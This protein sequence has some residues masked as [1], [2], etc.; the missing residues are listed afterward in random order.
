MKRVGLIIISLLCVFLI[1][2][3][4]A[5]HSTLLLDEY[6]DIG[7]DGEIVKEQAT[8]LSQDI[9]DLIHMGDS[10]IHVLESQLDSGLNSPTEITEST[11]L[12]ISDVETVEKK[13]NKF[14]LKLRV[15]DKSTTKFLSYLNS[16]KHRRWIMKNVYKLQN[17]VDD[18]MINMDHEMLTSTQASLLELAIL[19]ES[20]MKLKEMGET[21][22]R[23]ES[24]NQNNGRSVHQ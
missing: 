12:F 3:G 11:E 7:R 8:I 18:A 15:Y 20:Q 19:I 4:C 23:L 17:D 5:P 6:I 10:L 24:L 14:N 21:L 9:Q 13:L 1:M 22:D 16:S 2:P